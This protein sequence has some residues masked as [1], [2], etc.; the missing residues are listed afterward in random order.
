MFGVISATAVPIASMLLI[1]AAAEVK[2]PGTTDDLPFR[3]PT[4]QVADNRVIKDCGVQRYSYF[5]H[6]TVPDR[7]FYWRDSRG[8]DLTTHLKSR[9]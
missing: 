8:L 3:W 4:N 9:K 5:D 7:R 1:A 2:P 6:T